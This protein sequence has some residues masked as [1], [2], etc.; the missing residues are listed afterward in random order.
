LFD[1]GFFNMSP[2][3]VCFLVMHRGIKKL[4][5]TGGANRPYATACSR[6]RIR[7]DGNGRP[8]LR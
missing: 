7:G 3:E 6:Y 2:R 4:T 8:C 5:V 1:A